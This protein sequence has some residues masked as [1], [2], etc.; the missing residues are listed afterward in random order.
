[1]SVLSTPI[2]RKSDERDSKSS[3]PRN[4]K[5]GPAPCSDGATSNASNE[6]PRNNKK[7]ERL[8]VRANS[9]AATPGQIRQEEE[10]E[11]QTKSQ[12]TS[13]SM[14]IA[15]KAATSTTVASFP[16]SFWTPFLEQEEYDRQ[17][18]EMLLLKNR[19][20]RRQ[21]HQP[22]KGAGTRTARNFK[23]SLPALVG[24]THQWVAAISNALHAG[25]VICLYLI[26]AL[27]LFSF[28]DAPYLRKFVDSTAMFGQ[29]VLGLALWLYDL[30]THNLY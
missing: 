21:R 15:M 9:R 10:M 4:G 13:F 1:M 8:S 23:L 11:Y 7:A 16:D 3:T 5:H 30:C 28:L 25:L 22:E 17:K 26:L 18:R 20:I 19:E 27:F 12:R 2:V 6:T 29:V 14:A 24:S